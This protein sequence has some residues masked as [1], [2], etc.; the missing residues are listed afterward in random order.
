MK[1]I[2]EEIGLELA[3]NLMADATAKAV[4]ESAALGL[5]DAVKLDGAWCAR[6]PDG[7]V[8]PLNDY[9]ALEESSS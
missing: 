4:R 9:V 6:F 8:L 7:H 3:N 5:P 1:S 2:I